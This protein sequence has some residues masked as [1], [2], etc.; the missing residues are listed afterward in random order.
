[1]IRNLALTIG[2][3]LATVTAGSTRASGSAEPPTTQPADRAQPRFLQIDELSLDLSF[4][5]EWRRRTVRTDARGLGGRRFD[6]K[7]RDLRFGQSIGLT[8]RGSILGPRVLRYDLSLRAGLSQERFTEI[9]PGGDTTQTS[10]GDLFEYDLRLQAFP[11][12]RVSVSGFASKLDD[13]LPRPFLPSLQRRR[14][15]FGVEVTYSDATL[16]MSLLY[17]HL[18]DDLTSR[19]RGLVDDEERAE[20]RLR[21]EATWQPT[22]Y[23]SL[24]LEYEYERRSERF[25]GTRTRFDTTRSIL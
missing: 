8:S 3:A 15:R 21:Y 7:N 6:Q 5:S 11:A 13:R 22:E 20:D 25:S 19:T 16:P 2:V 14:E 9:V 18:F 24:H 1:M 4:E 23:H 12:G 10:H 17:E